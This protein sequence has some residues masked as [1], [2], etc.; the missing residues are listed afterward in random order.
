M[1]KIEEYL[2]IEFKK[3]LGNNLSLKHII[4]IALIKHATW[5]RWKYVKYMRKTDLYIRKKN[6]FSYMYFLWCERK[7]S[8]YGNILGFEINSTNIKKGITICHNGPIVI[9]KN[10]VAGE[11]LCLHGDNCIGNNGISD[12]CPILGDNVELGVGAKIIGNVKIG[13]NVVIGAGTIV[14]KDIPD[15]A[16]VV[17]ASNRIFIKQKNKE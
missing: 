12:E 8:K 2:N 14:V 9:H 1:E 4:H 6:I 13:N 16:T 10:V 3:T 7:K 17:G 11:N 5:L 15:D